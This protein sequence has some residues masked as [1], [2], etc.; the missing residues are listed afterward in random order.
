MTPARIERTREALR[1]VGVL[2][3]VPMDGIDVAAVILAVERAAWEPA[4]TVPNHHGEVLNQD[5]RIQWH[6]NLMWR[7]DSDRPATIDRLRD[8]PADYLA[9]L[10]QKY[11]RQIERKS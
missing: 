3:D 10:R 2:A 5:H 7:D 1:S 8:L 9:K 11:R 6:C 4:G